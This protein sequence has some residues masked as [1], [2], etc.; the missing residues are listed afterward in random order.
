MRERTRS[1]V[2]NEFEFVNAVLTAAVNAAERATAAPVRISLHA[3]L[4]A[5]KLCGQCLGEDRPLEAL[6][7]ALK[8]ECAAY[9]GIPVF[10]GA[11]AKKH[12]VLLELSTDF[13]DAFAEAAANYRHS[14]P[15]LILINKPGIAAGSAQSAYA[16]SMLYAYS[17]FDS[18]KPR[19]SVAAN[20]LF[21]CLCLFSMKGKAL[22]GA[23][24]MAVR[25]VLS[26]CEEGSVRSADSAA[27]AAA[28]MYA[29]RLS[30]NE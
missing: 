20:A 24:E 29:E 8:A 18:Q 10:A 27:M 4:A 28:L 21:R 13:L 23:H 3:R 30:V 19:T 9:E 7:N 25:A 26:A 2:A 22:A 1:I 6:T 17:R 12:C 16:R 14:L 15:E 11:S 5:V